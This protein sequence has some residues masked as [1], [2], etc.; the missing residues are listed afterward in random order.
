[1]PL[2]GD[3]LREHICR[4]RRFHF[5][6]IDSECAANAALSGR[7]RIA[8]MPKASIQRPVIADRDCSATDCRLCYADA[9]FVLEPAES[10]QRES[11]KMTSGRRC[12][13]KAR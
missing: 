9:R 13:G 11:A 8:G 4:R 3:S 7:G 2:A 10:D 5:Q 6:L 12:F 1:M